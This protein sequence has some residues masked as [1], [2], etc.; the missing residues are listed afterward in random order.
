MSFPQPS[1]PTVLK[2]LHLKV[3]THT[4]QTEKILTWFDQ[5]NQPALSNPIVWW[6][7]Q[8]AFKEGF[9]NVLDHAHQGLPLDTPIEIEA[10][11]FAHKIEIRIW[12]HGG[13]F[14]LQQK[15]KELP[16][17]DQNDQ[18]HGRGLKLMAKVIDQWSYAR[19]SDHRNCLLLVKHYTSS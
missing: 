15:L 10:L 13:Y 5:L 17:L 16:D 14:D 4:A 9:D 8:I 7:C 2:R 12:D 1:E 11:R 6:Q 3:T 19:T 18:D